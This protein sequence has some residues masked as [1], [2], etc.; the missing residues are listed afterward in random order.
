MCINGSFM[1]GQADL[2]TCIQAH[3]HSGHY[4]IF[5]FGVQLASKKKKK[6]EKDNQMNKQQFEAVCCH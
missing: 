3:L 1:A 5:P 2:S 4:F 6:K